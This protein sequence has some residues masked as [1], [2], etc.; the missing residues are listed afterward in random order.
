MSASE[1]E[2]YFGS[3]V[4]GFSM[5]FPRLQTAAGRAFLAR[6]EAEGKP[7]CAWTVND[8]WEMER[9][10]EMGLHA[11]ITDKPG[12]YVDLAD[13]VGVGRAE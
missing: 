9:C 12:L 8:P 13:E 3:A 4:T 10:I 2:H 6:A 5:W 7:V 1:A 11:V